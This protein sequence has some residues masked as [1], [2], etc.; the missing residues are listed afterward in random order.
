M[1]ANVYIRIYIHVKKQ[2]HETNV[3][4]HGLLWGK[5]AYS[6]GLLSIKEGLLYGIIS[7]PFLWATWLPRD[8]TEPV[9]RCRGTPLTWSPSAA[10]SRRG[11][12]R[13]GRPELAIVVIMV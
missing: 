3:R 11:C 4:I 6:F 8:V 1:Y 5:V 12:S 10:S 2:I 7:G 9:A 13:P